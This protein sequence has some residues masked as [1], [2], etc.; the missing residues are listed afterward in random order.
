MP[1]ARELRHLYRTPSWRAV[2]A[3]LK[4]RSGNRCE[5][6]MKPGG[7]IVSTRTGKGRM[8]WRPT[9]KSLTW[10]NEEGFSLTIEEYELA[11]S[12]PLRRIRVV[13]C[14]AHLNHT[15]GDD[16]AANAAFLCQWCHL[17]QD[18]GHHRDTRCRRKDAGRPLL[19]L[20]PMVEEAFFP[21]RS[22]KEG[23]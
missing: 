15:A 19:A 4:A 8:F 6:C 2:L 10:F 7:A 3:I 17:F 5:W 21:Q 18:K 22:L 13:L 11:L 14:G 23:A 20:D 9:G 16:R 1:V 12:L